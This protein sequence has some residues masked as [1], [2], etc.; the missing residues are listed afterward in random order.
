MARVNDKPV[1]ATNPMP[2]TMV[3]KNVLTGVYTEVDSATPL[4]VVLTGAAPVTGTTLIQFDDGLGNPIQISQSATL[5][6]VQRVEVTNL[7]QGTNNII[8]LDDG[9]GN[10]VIISHVGG[11]LNTIV[12][13]SPDKAL[14]VDVAGVPTPVA[15]TA[16]VPHVLNKIEDP[17]T[18]LPTTVKNVNGKQR[19]VATPYYTEVAAGQVPGHESYNIIA[20]SLLVPVLKDFA[21]NMALPVMPTAP[22]LTDAGQISIVS[23]SA[24]DQGAPEGFLVANPA[25]YPIATI[26][27]AVDSGLG[28]PLAGDTIQF[29]GDLNLYTVGTYTP[30]IAPA[31][32]GTITLLTG[33]LQPLV[34]NTAITITPLVPLGLTGLHV[35]EVHGLGLLGEEIVEQVVL[36]G[37]LPTLTKNVFS[38]LNFMHG[39]KCGISQTGAAGIITATWIPPV[40]VPPALPLIAQVWG[41]IDLS[42]TR[43]A[44]AYY[45]VPAGRKAIITQLLVAADQRGLQVSVEANVDPVSNQKIQCFLEHKTIVGDRGTV[46][47]E[48]SFPTIIPAGGEVR[49]TWSDTNNK[50]IIGHV[51]FEMLEENA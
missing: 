13:Q 42:E 27:I 24:I 14:M 16:T 28:V 39:V 46:A 10:P 44:S 3:V 50:G 31:T 23:T 20:N 26:V 35:I 17:T 47:Y 5:A 40:A 32:T 9:A 11:I 41:Q 18:G 43:S 6:G 22:T 49:L 48:F 1:S 30:P 45:K 33:L 51:A 21:S 38:T 15:Q 25:G 19:V 2:Q 8:E 4:Q 37:I 36:Q 29:A 34:D 12:T 7:N